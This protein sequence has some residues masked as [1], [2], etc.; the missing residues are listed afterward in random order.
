[1]E[2]PKKAP[3]SPVNNPIAQVLA[4]KKKRADFSPFLVAEL[5]PNEETAALS[6]SA[7]QPSGSSASE[8]RQKNDMSALAAA[9]PVFIAPNNGVSS[10]DSPAAE[11]GP[12]NP[13]SEENLLILDVEAEKI[14][15][16]DSLLGYAS[17]E[18]NLLPLGQLSEKLGFS[19]EVDPQQ[20]RADGWFIDEGRKFQLDMNGQTLTADGKSYPWEEGKIYS[21]D[22][23]IYIDSEL[24]SKIF[25]VDF[26]LSTAMMKLELDPREKL[27]LQ[28]QYEREQLREELKKR[29]DS[30][31]HYPL[32]KSS[33][34]FFSFPRIDVSTDTSFSNA[35][36]SDFS[37]PL[38]YSVQMNGDIAWMDGSLFLT[39][40]TDGSNTLRGSLSRYD[41]NGEL[42]GPLKATRFSL[43]DISP[44]SLPI[45]A[46]GGM[47]RGASITN[48]P[49]NR[50]DSFDTTRFEG[51]L[52]AGWDVELYQGSSL[53]A[54]QRVGEDSFYSFK[55]ISLNYG[56]NDFRIIGYGPQ[57][58]KRI[59]KEQ[60]LTVGG[61]MITPGA[62][63]YAFSASDAK[64]NLFS[65]EDNGGEENASSARIAGKLSYGINKNLSLNAGLSSVEFADKRHNYLQ[66][67]FAGTL[68]SLYGKG[69]IIVG[70]EGGTGLSLQGLTSLGGVNFRLRH[71]W[72]SG[73]EVEKSLDIKQRSSVAMNG[74]TP[75]FGWFPAV[76]YSFELKRTETSAG[77]SEEVKNR[78]STYIG[79]AHILNTLEKSLE[80]SDSPVKGETKVSYWAGGN[81]FHAGLD[82]TLGGEGQ[83]IHNYSLGGD[84]QLSNEL[85]LGTDLLYYPGDDEHG[86]IGAEVNWDAGSFLLTPSLQYD[87]NGDFSAG[88]SLSFSLSREPLT[89]EFIIN[90]DAQAEDG[91]V[92]AFVYNDANSNGL[93]DQGDEPI[94]DATVISPQQRKGEKTGEE[95]VAFF[96]SLQPHEI[97]DIEIDSKT[98][99]DPAWQ[100]PVEGVALAPRPGH[101]ERLE[102]PVVSTGELDGTIYAINKDGYPVEVGGLAL[103]L[104]NDQG[105][106]V[107]STSSEYDGFYLFQKIFPGEYTLR[108]KEDAEEAA[109]Y[110]EKS[111]TIGND[112]TIVGGNNIVLYNG[113]AYTPSPELLERGFTVAPRVEEQVVKNA[114]ESKKEAAEHHLQSQ[115]SPRPRK[116]ANQLLEEALRRSPAPRIQP[117]RG[118]FPAKEAAV[119]REEKPSLDFPSASG[120]SPERDTFEELIAS[121][122]PTGQDAAA[123]A[124]AAAAAPRAEREAASF[125][126]P[127]LRPIGNPISKF[128]PV[129]AP[130]QPFS[131]LASPASHRMQASRAASAYASLQ[132]G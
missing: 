57:G 68:S 11:N 128:T 75:G 82:Y 120:I 97:T 112:G 43:G 67:G 47:E 2:I 7:A 127:V 90:S 99:A 59:L 77:E 9:A 56:E 66:G 111:I 79:G 58:Q 38:N 123:M 24:L 114:E 48:M 32:R 52:P 51:S 132:A 121:S 110:Y 71:D 12:V 6:P 33:Y 17:N 20:G 46:G 62:F 22:D 85:S 30:G 88:V 50:S 101:I 94:E 35:G 126:Q 108:I 95:G 91:G 5:R 28:L 27:P 13:L 4:S 25:P 15:L 53:I 29:G 122:E 118:R 37:I 109:P 16:Q 131:P 14:G 74:R 76:N 72:Y 34:D 61:D 40:G 54:S 102:I 55:D 70:D 105:E 100:A 103:E 45:L 119:E 84:W 130:V 104:V 124:K 19:L 129:L 39:G 93:Y 10:V 96:P 26:N 106:V 86:T 41:V 80:N 8:T 117:E 83:R 31:Q 69:D 23:D 44:V 3:V 36:D 81:R 65:L 115:A 113:R 87:T 63:E 18:A 116:S 64:R 21:G 73:L 60:T 125:S 98:L 92:A 42:L 1:M 107:K 78:L 89:R 49:L